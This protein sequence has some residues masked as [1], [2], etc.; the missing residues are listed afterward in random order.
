MSGLVHVSEEHSPRRTQR[1]RRIRAKKLGVFLGVLCELGGENLLQ[2]TIEKLVYGGDGLARLP[3][4]ESGPGKTVFL[5]FVIPGEQ[6]EASL[7]Q[8]RPGFARAT[9]NQ[10]L[11]PSPER[12]EPG[13]PY[14]GRCGGCQY[15][16]IGYKSQLRYK[17]DILRETLR[18]TAKLELTVEIQTHAAEPWQY[19]NRTRL[20]VQHA[21]K[22]QIGYFRTGSHELLP[23]EQCPISSPLINQAIRAVLDLGGKGMAPTTLHGVQFFADDRDQQLLVEAYI[24]PGDSA[25]EVQAFAAALHELLPAMAGMVVFATSPVDDDS[26]QFAPLSAVHPEAGQ[27]IGA[28][29]LTYQAAGHVFR[30]SGGSFFQTN[31]FLVDELVRTAIPKLTGRAAL[32]LYA[33]AGLFSMA[34]SK[35]FDD[36]LAVEASPHS[37]A[38]LRH[39]AARNVKPIRAT[40]ENFLMERG[41]KLAPDFVIVDPPRAGMGEKPATALGRMSVSR[42]TYVSCDPATLARDLRPL[43]ESGFRVAEAH[44]V[45]LFPQTA[46]METVLHLAR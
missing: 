17:A 5:P 9:L 21:G 6:V 46:H 8:S 39:N 34:L 13:C 26:R 22:F 40:T 41:P 31:R 24:R 16:H 1:T 12:V 25:Q 4:D 35:S 28:D 38:D 33:G 10:V 32:D 3:A 36:V 19:R 29:A 42:V 37:F 23:I 7:A 44:L 18:R 30:V 15:Q 2:L 43:L 27:P 11:T 45:D 14:F 20:R